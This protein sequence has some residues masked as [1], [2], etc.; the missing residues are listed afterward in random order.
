MMMI[1]QSCR[2][3]LQAYAFAPNDAATWAAVTSAIGS[4][5]TGL[6]TQGGLQGATASAAFSVSCGLGTTMT[7]EDIL[8]GL[9]KVEVLVAIS[10]P[11]E[12]LVI[13]LQQQM[14]G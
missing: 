1:E 10:H 2:A 4:F 8:N 9:L 6:W 3:A 12:F 11:A 14:A 13:T 7:A 5:L